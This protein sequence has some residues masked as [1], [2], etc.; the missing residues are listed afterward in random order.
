[1]PLYKRFPGKNIDIF[2][3]IIDKLEQYKRVPKLLQE[4]VRVIQTSGGDKG[5]SHHR[6]L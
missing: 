5:D 6:R 4:E 1:M 3:L 2:D